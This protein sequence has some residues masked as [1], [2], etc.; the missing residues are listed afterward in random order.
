MVRVNGADIYT[1]SVG[2]GREVVVI[3]GGPGASHLSLLPALDG[4]ARGLRLR[5]YDQRGCG[6]S[7]VAPEAPLGWRHH[8]ED[9]EGLLDYWEIERATVIA[10]SWGA[11]LSL[12]YAMEY[13]GRLQ[14]V[15]LIAPACISSADR[16]QFL[17]RL[18]S[19]M[20]DLEIQRKQRELV[21][22][23]LRRSNPVAFRRR[24]LELTMA[25]FLKEPRL[26]DGLRTYS[27]NHRVREAVWR[28]L[29]DYDLTDAVS[30]LTLD[31]FIIHGRFDL[32]PPSSSRQIARSL[33]ARL[34]FFENS[35]HMPFFEEYERFLQVAR[36]ATCG[37]A[38]HEGNTAT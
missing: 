29:G 10:H 1:R 30:R 9:L 6:E 25:P 12:L 28:S 15:L 19:R 37:W 3:H 24:A 26:P 2:A 8:V 38:R 4:L 20:S 16:R 11:L 33:D 14:R 31:A 5:Y 27:I 34:E 21:R 13:A 17:D 36:V 18:S 7:K 35:G 23:G 22:S 32:I